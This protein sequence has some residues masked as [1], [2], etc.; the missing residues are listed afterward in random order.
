MVIGV[1][2]PRTFWT[3]ICSLNQIICTADRRVVACFYVIIKGSNLTLIST[4]HCLLHLGRKETQ[5]PRTILYTRKTYC[6]LYSSNS[7]SLANNIFNK[8]LQR[9][10]LW[11]IT[12]EKTDQRNLS[13]WHGCAQDQCSTGTF[14]VGLSAPYWSISINY[15]HI[16]R[17]F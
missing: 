7:I 15:V 2:W 5:L 8:F 10:F 16:L 6:S 1:Q 17:L 12:M 13:M 14:L 11:N 4:A 3:D 9:S